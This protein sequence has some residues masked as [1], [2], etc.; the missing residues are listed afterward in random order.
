[1]SVTDNTKLVSDASDTKNEFNS[2]ESTPDF[3]TVHTYPK[4]KERGNGKI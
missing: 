1:M 4:T 2:Q 3:T